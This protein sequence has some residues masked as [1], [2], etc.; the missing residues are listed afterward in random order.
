MF[1]GRMLPVCQHCENEIAEC[2]LDGFNALRLQ[3]LLLEDAKKAVKEATQVFGTRLAITGGI[4]ERGY[5]FHDVDVHNYEKYV[6]SRDLDAATYISRRLKILVDVIPNSLGGIW[7]VNGHTRRICRHEFDF[8]PLID[9]PYWCSL[10]HRSVSLLD[11]DA[12]PKGDGP[13]PFWTE[14]TE[15]ER[16]E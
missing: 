9:K 16:K 7:H 10:F 15:V 8:D 1:K 12:C 11:C 13:C 14:K 4:E 2:D 5:T 6:S 3:P